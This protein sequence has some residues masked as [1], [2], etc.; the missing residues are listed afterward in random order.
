MRRHAGRSKKVD[1][2]VRQGSSFVYRSIRA[3]KP[4][5]VGALGDTYWQRWALSRANAER[6]VSPDP[7]SGMATKSSTNTRG[8]ISACVEGV[9]DLTTWTGGSSVSL[10]RQRWFQPCASRS[11]AW[12][13]SPFIGSHRRPRPFFC[14]FR[15]SCRLAVS[16]WKE[17]QLLRRRARTAALSAAVCGADMTSPSCSKVKAGKV[18]CAL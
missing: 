9:L 15:P 11:A 2:S 3:W 6:D 5:Q 4:W 1:V 13:G 17:L 7:L 18:A 14:A 12:R 16:L 10:A 8:S